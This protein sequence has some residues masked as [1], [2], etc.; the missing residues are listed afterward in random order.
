MLCMHQIPLKEH[1][2]LQPVVVQAWFLNPKICYICFSVWW[3]GSSQ[4]YY[5][6]LGKPFGVKDRTWVSCI[7]AHPL[8]SFSAPINSIIKRLVLLPSEAQEAWSFLGLR[9]LCCCAALLRLLSIV[10]LFLGNIHRHPWQYVGDYVAGI[11]GIELSQPQ[12]GIFLNLFIIKIQHL[13]EETHLP[14]PSNQI[15]L[16]T[17]R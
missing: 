12:Q 7:K 17:R 14:C 15:L 4:S 16:Q 11:V 13:E 3:L 6:M 9:I 8:N 10:W 1:L 5:C 2:L